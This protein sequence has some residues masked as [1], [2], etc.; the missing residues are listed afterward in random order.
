MQNQLN[1]HRTKFM[2]MNKW[3]WS[4]LSQRNCFWG[5]YWCFLKLSEMFFD[6]CCIQRHALIDL[7]SLIFLSWPREDH[8]STPIRE[9]QTIDWKF[10][11]ICGP[12]K[13][14]TE[15]EEDGRDFTVL[16]YSMMTCIQRL[17]VF[18][19][20]ALSFPTW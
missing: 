20:H 17:N 18:S 3:E 16:L 6:F 8:P 7:A 4:S 15:L 1:P 14:F 19:L 10:K 5:V 12:T 2:H 11:S 13:G 9:G